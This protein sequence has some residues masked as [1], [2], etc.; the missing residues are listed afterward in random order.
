M[1]LPE[2]KQWTKWQGQPRLSNHH[3]G[4]SAQLP[5]SLQD[6]CAEAG[7]LSDAATATPGGSL[8]APPSPPDC[9]Q[10][11]HGTRQLAQSVLT[12][13]PT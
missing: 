2:A 5:A 1:A 7:P 3:Q 12:L 13:I 11:P 6:P 8:P 4:H 9:P 10:L